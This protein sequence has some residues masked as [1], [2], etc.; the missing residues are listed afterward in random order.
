MFE[1]GRFEANEVAAWTSGSASLRAFAGQT[2]RV[3]IEA[4]DA[5]SSSLVE[6]AVDDVIVTHMP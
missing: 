1:L 4:V 5:G 2:I 3:L 6:A